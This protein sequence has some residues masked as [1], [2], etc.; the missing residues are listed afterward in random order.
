M[1][2][3]PVT[4]RCGPCFE[5]AP[6]LSDPIIVS[7]TYF[8]HEVPLPGT[9]LGRVPPPML[10]FTAYGYTDLD[11]VCEMISKTAKFSA[12]VVRSLLYVT[13]QHSAAVHTQEEALVI[14]GQFIQNGPSSGGPSHHRNGATPT[15]DLLHANVLPH[16]PQPAAKMAFLAHMVGIL[17]NHVFDPA[18]RASQQ[19]DKAHRRPRPARDAGDFLGNKRVTQGV[20]SGPA[21]PPR[22]VAI[23]SANRSGRPSTACGEG[24]ANCAMIFFWQNVPPWGNDSLGPTPGALWSAT[25]PT[26]P[27][28]RTGARAQDHDLSQPAGQRGAGPLEQP[29]RSPP[30]ER[31]PTP[32]TL[33]GDHPVRHRV[34]LRLAPTWNARPPR[35]PNRQVSKFIGYAMTTGN[36]STQP[37]HGNG[38][39][40]AAAVAVKTGIIQQV[41][42]MNQLSIQPPHTDRCSVCGGTNRTSVACAPRWTVWAVAA[43][44]D[45]CSLG[46]PVS[47][48][49]RPHTSHYGY[50]CPVETQEGPAC[51]LLVRSRSKKKNTTIHSNGYAAKAFALGARVTHAP[52][53]AQTRQLRNTVLQLFQEDEA[54]GDMHRLPYFVFFNGEPRRGIPP[55]GPALCGILGT[56]SD[57]AG[58]AQRVRRCEEVCMQ[59][60]HFAPSVAVAPNGHVYI[61]SDEGRLVRP[62]LVC[63]VPRNRTPVV[64]CTIPGARPLCD[65]GGG[66]PPGAPAPLRGCHREQQPRPGH[67]PCGVHRSC[68]RPQ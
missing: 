11:F 53:I 43:S 38:N 31:E 30:R 12:D 27:P 64:V 13:L 34:L 25:W 59:E 10:L 7:L 55:A 44:P 36:W 42:S 52:A 62:L 61:S 39:M 8:R 37:T 41:T 33:H 9:P 65:G 47:G 21:L 19:Y 6:V 32:R 4:P 49:R 5:E 14:L 51:G 48:M 57:T 60:L 28:S 22:S 50:L 17:L 54:P 58:F 15:E 18:S 29:C 23:C 24:R 3:T 40:M 45:S 1:P 16:L 68:L 66:P 2:P 35:R 63:P 46:V 56:I 26:V 67:R 20:P